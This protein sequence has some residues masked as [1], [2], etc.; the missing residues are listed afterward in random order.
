MF[1]G[2][3]N[4]RNAVIH[5]IDGASF[6]VGISLCS[7]SVIMP[8]YVKNFTQNPFL[9]AMIPFLVDVGICIPQVLSAF[10]SHRRGHQKQN[11]MIMNYFFPALLTRFS[12][13]ALGITTLVFAGNRTA[14]LGSFY[15]LIAVFCLALGF[16]NPNWINI[17]SMTIHDRIRSDFLGKREFFARIA[18]ILFTFLLPVIL[19]IGSFPVNYGYL[20]IVAGVVMSA[21]IFP[22]LLYRRTEPSPKNDPENRTVSFTAFAKNSLRII[23]HNKKLL[24]LLA[25]YWSLSIS[26]ISTAFY[27]PYIIDN[28]LSRQSQETSRVLLSAINLTLLLS[29]A[30][31]SPLFGKLIKRIGHV[32]SIIIGVGSLFIAIVIILAFPSMVTAILGQFFLAV[33]T[34]SAYL[35]SL[36]AVMDYA[37]PADRPVISAFNNSINAVFITFFTM[38]GGTIASFSGF[39]AA[40]IFTAILA[41]A[42]LIVTLNLQI[43]KI[44][45]KT[46]KSPAPWIE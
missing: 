7:F 25:V 40:L 37:K 27:T 19:S 44:R 39:E 46:K 33:F 34:I 9:L 29:M 18:G 5:V 43:G 15:V 28:I 11:S 45:F 24:A 20:F 30:V 10:L 36:N 32:N 12:F 3:K 41:L 22:S 35:V 8:S 42:I 6:M 4:S 31:A 17:L 26:R 16:T 2:M 38:L 13:I 21:G 1:L 23:Y 14:A